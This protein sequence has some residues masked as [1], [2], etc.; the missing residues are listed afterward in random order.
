MKINANELK[1]YVDKEIVFE[2][3]VD[4]IRDIKW[5]QFVILKDNTGKV[6]MTIEK[7]LEDN[8]EMV[9]LIST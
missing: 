1:N 9:E 8:K 3:F 6:Q 4:A 2:G 7:S 5:V